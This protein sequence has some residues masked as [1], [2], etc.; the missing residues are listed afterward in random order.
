MV[1]TVER[2]KDGIPLGCL[3]QAGAQSLEC[4]TCCSTCECAGDSI[5]QSSASSNA[6]WSYSLAAAIGVVASACCRDNVPG[7]S[8]KSSAD[9]TISEHVTEPQ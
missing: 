3:C 5:A 2:L 4:L 1:L 9:V 6:R 8:F 7:A